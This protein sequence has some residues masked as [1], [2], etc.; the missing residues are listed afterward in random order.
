MEE[1]TRERK[2]M[3][4]WG[5]DEAAQDKQTEGKYQRRGKREENDKGKGEEGGHELWKGGDK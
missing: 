1:K 3:R 5:R 2:V 4:R